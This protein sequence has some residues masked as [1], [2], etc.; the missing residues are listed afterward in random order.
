MTGHDTPHRTKKRFGQHFLNDDGVVAALIKAI[1]PSPG[2]DL[3]EI[4]P[5]LGVL[6]GPLLDRAGALTVVEIDRDLAA[7]LH[8]RLAVSPETLEII[9]VDVLAYDFPNPHQRVVGN[10]PYNI[11]TPLLFHLFARADRVVDMHF[12]LQKEVVDRLVA[13]PGT[14]AYGRLS[15]MAQYHAKMWPLFDVPPEAFDPPPK[16]DS[17]VIRL[18]PK[19]LDEH[20]HSLAGSLE[21]VVRAAFGQRRKTLRNTLKTL[22]DPE[23]MTRAG[24]DPGLRAE[25]LSV[26]AFL[27]LA[28]IH[29]SNKRQ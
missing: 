20:T 10:L 14:K 16:V 1:N 24:I 11:S 18:V 19:D 4:G 6:T 5:G 2:D 3:I 28:E 7:T 15:V 13:A 9:N 23:S 29:Q 26:E 27:Q 17:A 8:Q 12:M 25:M 21:V 22:I